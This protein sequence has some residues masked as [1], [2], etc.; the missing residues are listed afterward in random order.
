MKNVCKKSFIAAI[1]FII[2]LPGIA[3]PEEVDLDKIVIT[4]TKTEALQSQVGTSSTVISSDQI[5]GNQSIDVSDTLRNVP[6]ISVS[7]SGSTGSL[8]DIYMRGAK[9]E[10]T[11]VMIDGVAVNDPMSAGRSF[12]FAH[13]TADNIE[14]IEVI[15]GPQS[16]LY[17]A[18][19]V[20]GA[21]N[22]ITKKGPGK[23]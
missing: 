9:P 17:G 11:L 16:T 19:A 21:I 7:Q 20:G 13:L 18:D 3:Q 4:P 8:T 23:P 10:Y 12:D 1:L 15:R 22:I 6:G 14:R 2:I 5:E